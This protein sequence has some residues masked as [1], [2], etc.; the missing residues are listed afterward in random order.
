METV[1]SIMDKMS[2]EERDVFSIKYNE[3]KKS[4]GTAFFLC[5]LLGGFGAHKFYLKQNLMG[6]LYLLF[7]W[8]YVPAILAL[9]ELL[10]ING[11]TKKY[12]LKLAKQISGEQRLWQNMH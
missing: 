9:I 11:Y 2:V 10:F 7:F 8:S 6:M 5:L 3:Q 4:G 12:N 1:E